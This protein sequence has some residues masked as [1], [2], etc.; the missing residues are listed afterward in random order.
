MKAKRLFLIIA[1]VLLLTAAAMFIV[2]QLRRPEHSEPQVRT[3]TLERF[4]EFPSAFVSPRTVSVW[5]PDGY[6]VGQPCDVLY[7]HDGQ[8][9]FD[10]EATWNHQE[11][12]VDEVAGKLIAEGQIPQCIVVGIDNTDNRLKEY[13]PEKAKMLADKE[14]PFGK[15]KLQGDAYLRFIVEELKPFID[16][17]YHP[18]TDRKHTFM[19]GSSMGGLIS[20]Y[21][22]CEYP[23]IFGGVG[24]LSSHLSMALLPFGNGSERMAKAFAAYVEDNL[25]AANTCRVYMDHGTKGFDAAYGRYQ[26]AIDD[27]FERR[28]WDDAHYRSLVFEGDDHNETCWSNRLVEPLEFLLVETTG[29]EPVTPCL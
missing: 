5:L 15:A 20:L 26:S 14:K 2:M 29:F 1:A 25:P 8:M 4:P 11:W 3:G 18:L 16:E 22:L 17:K 21:A 28:G 23:D 9:L 12:A 13:F 19:M 10:A 24:C 27:I 6:E 7:M